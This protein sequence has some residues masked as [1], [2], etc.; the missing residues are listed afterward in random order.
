MDDIV[1]P[2]EELQDAVQDA[3]ASGEGDLLAS[4]LARAFEKHGLVVLRS[5]E[6]KALTK[7]AA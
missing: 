2:I 4:H 3:I 5:S 6:L 1:N 7:M